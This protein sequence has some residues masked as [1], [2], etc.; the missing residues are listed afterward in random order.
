MEPEVDQFAI[1]KAVLGS[2]VLLLSC[3]HSDYTYLC[4]TLGFVQN[5]N[6]TFSLPEDL[7]REAKVYAAQHDTTMNALVRQL[8]EEKVSAEVRARAAAERFLELAEKGPY[9]T[10]DPGTIRREELYERW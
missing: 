7:V 4:V 5:R 1:L 10:V 9:S 3:I 8:L 2:A 6:I